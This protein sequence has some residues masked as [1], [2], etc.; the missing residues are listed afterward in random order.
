M[1]ESGGLP[2]G[3]VTFL[4]TD[5]EGS[6][7]LWE[8]HPD[9]MHDALAR[10]DELLRSA[11]ES[12]HGHV[13]KTTGDGF[14]AAFSTA[15]DAVLAAV[16]AQV[17][18][19]GEAWS[20]TGPLRVRM[21]LHTGEARHR[22]GDYFGP[23]LNRAARIMSAGHGGQVL[24]SHATEEL[25]RDALADGCE[26][27]SL[28]E[29]QLRDLGRPEV[30]FQLTHADLQ[31]D[32]GRVRSLDAYPGNLPLQVTSFVGRAG[33]MESVISALEEA[34][35][36]TL[37]GV[38]GVGKTRLALQVAGE[39]LPKFPD[40][41]WLVELA[42]A[43]DADALVQVVATV[44]GVTSHPTVSLESRVLH[45]LRDQHLLLVLDNCEHL[46]DA[47]SR[48]ASAILR[49]CGAVRLLAT[50]REPLDV[51]GEHVARVRSLPLPESADGSTTEDAATR[52]DCSWSALAARNRISR[53]TRRPSARSPRSAAGWTASRWRSSWP[54]PASCR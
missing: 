53:S 5:L 23:E 44:V 39:L 46:L 9:A 29:H 47:A 41:S 37:T 40:G 16:S 49:E 50:S 3:T 36:V 1:P 33:D 14:H 15:R 38:G 31:R 19:Y 20:D 54:R 25:V 7:R 51:D 13:V 32:F 22:G 2:S 8:E 52:C 48:M 6:T 21:G 24:L 28:G 18:L 17:A 35:L 30:L 10:H 42:T 27:V 34:R 4:F 26:L 12:H 11:I 45:R 43:G